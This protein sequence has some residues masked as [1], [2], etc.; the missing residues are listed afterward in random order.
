[1]SAA[2]AAAPRLLILL[3]LLLFCCCVFDRCLQ[4]W[5][6]LHQTEPCPFLEQLSALLQQ[7]LDFDDASA[8][9]EVAGLQ[10][11]VANRCVSVCLWL[12]LCNAVL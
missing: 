11:H 7:Q 1:M 6:L 3:L 9:A 8:P 5:G 4:Q 12:Q 2:H 10:C